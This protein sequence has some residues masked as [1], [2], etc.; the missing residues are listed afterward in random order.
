MAKPDTTGSLPASSVTDDQNFE[1]DINQITTDYLVPIDN[2]R[3]FANLNSNKNLLS[4]LTPTSDI[5]GLSKLL[6][7]EKTVQESRCHAF[8]RLIGFPIVADG[9]VFY[10][11]G[12]DIINCL[13]K[14]MD[15]GT[16]IT[17]AKKPLPGFNKLSEDRELYSQNDAA[18]FSIPNSIDAGVL[19]LCSGGTQKLRKFVSP[20]DQDSSAFDGGNFQSK[21]QSYN[22]DTIALVGA[23]AKGSNRVDLTDFQDQN[24]KTPS[25]FTSK[26]FHIIKP[27]IVDPRIDFTVQPQ[28]KLVAVPFVPD[29]SFT[30]VSATENVTRPL[31]E[32]IIRDRLT[33]QDDTATAGTYV[34]SILSYV[35]NIPA[36]KDD[37]LIQLVGNKALYKNEQD[38]FIDNVNTIRTMMTKLVDSIRIIR[39][40]QGKYYYVPAPSTSGPEGGSTVRGVFLPNVIDPK[41]VTPLDKSIFLSIAKGATNKVNSD[42]ASNNSANDSP[43]FAIGT[44]FGPDTSTALGDNNATNQETLTQT[45][46]RLMSKANEALETIEIIMGEF[47]GLGLCDIVA[48]IGALNIISKDK[49]VGLLDDGAYQRMQNEIPSAKDAE[50]AGLEESLQELTDRVKDFYNLM[51]KI[52]K[53]IA[54][55]NGV[56]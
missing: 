43:S 19:A 31:I 36:I 16:K 20:M 52:Y 13:N 4:S 39:T 28:S 26:R 48:I 38:K 18:V 6:K 10:N 47:S 23:N 35:E 24:G 22:V 32:K 34:N 7:I 40:V 14:Q 50:R 8:F 12:F 21:N 51:D 44:T 9:G 5:P 45:R 25:K 37:A 53:D 2:I 15:L 49:L 55:H 11:P 30:K 41:L 1:I 3:S 33:V 29:N 27:F 42:T 54:N 56:S 46:R 17:I